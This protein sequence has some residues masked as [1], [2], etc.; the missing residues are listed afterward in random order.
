MVQF[1]QYPVFVLR[2]LA[3][4]ACMT[5]LLAAVRGF[6]ERKRAVTVGAVLGS[7]LLSGAGIALFPLWTA[8]TDY[9]TG[10]LLYGAVALVPVL[11][12]PQVIL[13]S[14]RHFSSAL[15]CFALNVGMEGL[16]SVF[17]Y[18]FDDPDGYAYHF[19][20]TVFCTAGYLLTTLFLRRAIRGRDRQIIRTTVDLIP[21]WL[22]AVVVV[23][24][25]YSF[26]SVMGRAPEIYNFE[27]TAAIL[28]GIAVL[29]TVLFAGY[30]VW[31]VFALTAQQNR[32]LLQMNVQ[33]QNYERMLK[34]DE[35]LRRFRHD[36][37]NHM[38]VVTSLLNA[39]RMDEATE[40]LETIKISAGMG[41]K[42]FLTGN[43]AADA[44]LNNKL[45][46][47]RESGVEL[48]FSGVVP[49]RGIEHAD[50]CA[51]LG[52]LIDN[53]VEG[54]ARFPGERVVNVRAAVR[55]GF[56]T[57]SVT[58]PVER[59]VPIRNNRIRTT[60]ADAGS[61]GIG[62]KNVAA[63]VRKYHGTLTLACDDNQFTADAAM[64]L[65]D[66]EDKETGGRSL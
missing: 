65:Q 7:V 37:K 54:A 9:D 23:C 27:K 17:G 2:D 49:E 29:G 60:K 51:V 43:F 59:Q 12:T 55:N 8:R 58:N 39:G 22:Y 1:W 40:Y 41:E 57:L 42:R 36:Y 31:K 5:V 52:N 11:I 21:K 38:L 25:F 26:F 16:F 30:F 3:A 46:Q 45:A 53:A 35:Q 34:D 18:A 44:I 33:Q 13:R 14:S 10:F 63:A 6:G 4:L 24:S 66:S 28:R 48:S 19:Y 50:L 56:L 47:A 15:I 62:L 64:R 32:I 61:H 20:E